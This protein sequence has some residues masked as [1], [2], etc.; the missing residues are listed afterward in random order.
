[1]V[2]AEGETVT[3]HFDARE[4]RSPEEREA[5]LFGRLPGVLMAAMAAPAYA[6]RLAGIDPAAVTD[7]AALARLPILR[8]SELPAL[9]KA[10]PPFGG[11]VP[12]AA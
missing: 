11:C 6:E 3:E 10:A 2:R 5:D 7:R 9:H 12:G 4:T 8:K 1:M